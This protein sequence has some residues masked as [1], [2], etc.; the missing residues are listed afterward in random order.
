MDEAGACMAAL[1][2]I[3]AHFY[4]GIIVAGEATHNYAQRPYVVY[5]CMW[6]AYPFAGLALEEEWVFIG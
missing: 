6:A 4:F 1:Q 3:K 2:H 5:P